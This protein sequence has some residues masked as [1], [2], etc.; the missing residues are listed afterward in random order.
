[1]NLAAFK[2][3]PI[4][5]RLKVEVRLEATGATNTPNFDA[6]GTNMNQAGTF[7][8][9]SSAGGSRAMQGSARLVF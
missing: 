2:A 7:G 1:L 9:I 5:E 6:P 3:F 8:V 4:R